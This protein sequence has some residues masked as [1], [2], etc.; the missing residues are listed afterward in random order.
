MKVESFSFSKAWCYNTCR[1]RFA[2]KYRLWL[3][4]LAKD[5]PFDSWRRLFMGQLIHAGLEA[6]ML[7]RPASIEIGLQI[8]EE[9]A[10][11]L[12]DEQETELPVMQEEAA[13]IVENF[14]E[15]LPVTDWEVVKNPHTGAPLIECELRVPLATGGDFLGYVDAVLKHKATGRVIVCDYK[16]KKALGAEGDEEYVTQLPMYIEALRRLDIVHTNTF[17]LLEIK[18]S[19]P[20]RAPR[21]IR[22]DSESIDGI[23]ESMDGCFRYVPKFC[24]DHYLTQTWKNFEKLA[25]NMG[26]F[27]FEHEYPNRSSFNCKSCEYRNLCNAVEYGADTKSVLTAGYESNP[28]ALAI[29]DGE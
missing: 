21:K 19:T 1:R 17:A 4:P 14:C 16:S 20:K 28:K 26:R 7:G 2:Y 25:G 12:R 13:L 11:G 10:K 3:K 15:W 5:A 22:Y 23:R 8:D 18:S 24:S 9:R 6:A 27:Q 29:F